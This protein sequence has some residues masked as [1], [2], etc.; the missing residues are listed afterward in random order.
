[1]GVSAVSIL[2]KPRPDNVLEMRR[3]GSS[4]AYEAAALE[5][6]TAVAITLEGAEPLAER[7]AHTLSELNLEHRAE[8]RLGPFSDT[9]DVAIADLE[10]V[11]SRSSKVTTSRTPLS[12][13]WRL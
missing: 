10:H 7:S 5:L 8:V 6:T 11:D 3:R 12:S 2:G 4:A 9:L 13:T 1:M